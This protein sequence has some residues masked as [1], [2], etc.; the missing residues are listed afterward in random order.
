MGGRAG[1]PG[2]AQPHDPQPAARRGPGVGRLHARL[3]P[4]SRRPAKGIRPV[5]HA[6]ARCP[7][8]GRTRC[9]TSKRLERQGRALHLP[10]RRTLRVGAG[11][12]PATSGSYAA[13]RRRSCGTARPPPPGRPV[14]RPLGDAATGG[15]EPV[16]LAGAV[17]RPAGPVSWDVS[18]TATGDA[19]AWRSSV[20]TSLISPPTTRRGLF[21]VR[22]DGHH[23]GGLRARRAGGTTWSRG[24]LERG[25]GHARPAAPRTATTE[26][27]R[28]PARRAQA[29]RGRRSH[30]PVPIQR[31]PLRAGRPVCRGAPRKG[32]PRRSR[33]GRASASS[34]RM[35]RPHLPHGHRVQGA[36]QRTTGVAYPLAGGPNRFDS[37]QLGSAGCRRQRITWDTPTHLGRHVQLLLP[38]A[39]VHAGGVPR[40]AGRSMSSSSSPTPRPVWRGVGAP[41]RP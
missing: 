22:V 34:T 38:G 21:L 1:R 37:G 31:L 30:R 32:A 29:A 23:A 3:L 17:L 4:D 2:G 41:S 16:P 28:R 15:Q 20:A 5:K 33:P 40:Q 9:S 19:G 27:G 8:P 6:V 24:K 7:G 36:L 39:P 14:D 10:R 12:G 13:A 11:A 18:M 35:R 25:Q 26:A